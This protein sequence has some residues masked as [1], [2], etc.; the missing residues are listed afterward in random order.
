ME[1]TYLVIKQP[2]NESDGRL[3][4]KAGNMPSRDYGPG[5]INAYDWRLWSASG[6]G[7]RLR[8]ML[9][10]GDG[11]K[12]FEVTDMGAYVVVRAAYHSTATGEGRTKTFVIAFD[13]PKVGDGKIFTTSTKWRTFSSVQQA[14]SYI[15]ST[16]N[17]FS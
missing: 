2:V 14:A 16:V 5:I 4:G 13:D 12:S 17:S 1:P 10:A 3:L 9:S 6:F 15:N 11:K 7:N 8:G